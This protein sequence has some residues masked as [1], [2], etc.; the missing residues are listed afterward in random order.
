MYV[1]KKSDNCFVCN[2]ICRIVDLQND[3]IKRNDKFREQLVQTA[4]EQQ[5]ETKWID[6]IKEKDK[7]LTDIRMYVHTYVRTYVCVCC[8]VCI[9]FDDT[10]MVMNIIVIY[11][12]RKRL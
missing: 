7:R 4:A 9:A 11:R 2:F 5:V 10:T 3:A 1:S 6:C 8:N 12:Q